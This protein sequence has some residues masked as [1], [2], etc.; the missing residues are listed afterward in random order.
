MKIDGD[1]KSLRILL[2]TKGRKG[3]VVTIISGFQHNPN[4]IEEIAT[5]LKQHC[6]A[7]GTVKGRDIEIQGDQRKKVEEK[8]ILLNF[9][10]K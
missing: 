6:G 1:K 7:G 3:K 5:I 10:V 2:D 9:V 4:V 8:L